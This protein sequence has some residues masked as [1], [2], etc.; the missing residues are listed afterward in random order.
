MQTGSPSV[1]H[2]RNANILVATN[3]RPFSFE[4]VDSARIVPEGDGQETLG[5]A[6][7]PVSGQVM[8]TLPGSI[9]RLTRS[10]RGSKTCPGAIQNSGHSHTSLCYP[11]GVPC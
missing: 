9:R 2:L 4:D 1:D 7:Q 6:V 3:R 11:D 8:A 10:D 5:L